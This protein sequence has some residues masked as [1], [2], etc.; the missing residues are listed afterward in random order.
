MTCASDQK[1]VLIVI[2]NYRTPELTL[3]CLRSLAGESE[4]YPHMRVAVTDNNSQDGSREIIESFLADQ[5]WDWTSFQPL[6]DNAG[7]SAGNNAAI[8][9]HLDANTLPEYVMLLNPDT[10]IRAGAIRSLC[11]FMDR[12]PD[13]GIAGS[14]LEDPD[15]SVQRSA[16]RFHSLASE[17]VSACRLNIFAT[18]F[19]HKIVAPPPPTRAC[20]TDWVA[21]ASMIIRSKVIQQ[22]GLLDPHY[23]MYF[24]EVDFCLRARRANWPCAFVPESRVVHLVGQASGVTTPNRPAK[25]R[26]AYWFA[27]RRRYFLKNHGRAYLT[28]ANILWLVGH[29][30]WRLRRLI[31]RKPDTDPPLM[32][33]DFVRYNFL[34]QLR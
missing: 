34:G 2:V 33:W 6:P 26:P 31:Q 13:V 4:K 32:M 14:R 29:A 18:M 27:S 17:W 8:V 5:G 15:G 16:F 7:F 20:R 24:E 19:R 12:H 25:R 11:Q 21:G 3:Q 10:Y 23:F 28:A 30:S 22:I 1:G 9:A